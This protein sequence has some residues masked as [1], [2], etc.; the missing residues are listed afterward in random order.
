MG[1]GYFPKTKTSMKNGGQ[2][3]TQQASLLGKWFA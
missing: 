2:R 3:E 1:F